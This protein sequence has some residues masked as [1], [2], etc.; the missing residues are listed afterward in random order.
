MSLNDCYQGFF[1]R[2]VVRG[3]VNLE[4]GMPRGQSC[5]SPVKGAESRAAGEPE[6]ETSTQLSR[7]SNATL[8]NLDFFHEPRQYHQS[9]LIKKGSDNFL[10]VEMDFSFPNKETSTLISNLCLPG[11]AN[12]V[13]A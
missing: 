6:R 12:N 11:G 3:I 8:R 2:D 7:A 1:R 5:P 10:V 13:L 4:I 9:S